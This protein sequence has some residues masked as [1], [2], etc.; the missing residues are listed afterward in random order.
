MHIFA[1]GDASFRVRRR[2]S[3]RAAMGIV[4]GDDSFRPLRRPD[5]P[6][7]IHHF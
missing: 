6:A 2:Q 1:C 3:S 5:L 7:S 4:A